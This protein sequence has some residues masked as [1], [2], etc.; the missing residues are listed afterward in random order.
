VTRTDDPEPSG[1][2][3][4]DCSL[5]EAV[6]AANVTPGADTITVPAGYYALERAMIMA[7]GRPALGLEHLAAELRGGR[8]GQGRRTGAVSLKDTERRQ[9]ERVLKL[10]SGNR[11]HAARDLG[12]SRV[13][14][15]KKLR[16]YGL[17]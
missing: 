6:V 11:T 12:I 1:C 17:D 5:R 8:V 9:I 7:R 4:G 15:L 10:N 16:E 2:S 3:P 13:T 14:L